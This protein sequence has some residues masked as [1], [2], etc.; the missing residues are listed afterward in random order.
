MTPLGSRTHA[1]LPLR[2]PAEGPDAA[3]DGDQETAPGTPSP[4]RSPKNRTRFLDSKFV[5]PWEDPKNR[6]RNS[7]TFMGF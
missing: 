4:E 1:Q 5:E 2:V 3:L 6:S 7:D